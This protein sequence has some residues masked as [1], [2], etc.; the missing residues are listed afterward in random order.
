MTNVVLMA[1]AIHASAHNIPAKGIDVAGYVTGSADILW[2]PAD[3]ARFDK[4]TGILRIDQSPSLSVYANGHAHIA[5]IEAGAA[6]VPAWINASKHRLAQNA[7]WFPRAYFSFSRIAEVAR[8]VVSAGIQLGSCGFWVA[9]WNLNLAGASALVGDYQIPGT[10]MTV[11]IRAVQWASPSSNPNTQLPGTSMT[12]KAANVDLSVKAAAWFAG[13]QPMTPVHAALVT[14]DLKSRIV[15][16]VD[17]G[18]TW[19]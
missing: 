2:T 11:H 6:T 8:A 17:S 16:S 3:F 5:D 7:A 4:T 19:S 14:S 9:D 18:K 13:T 12:L 10:G 1:D 15:T